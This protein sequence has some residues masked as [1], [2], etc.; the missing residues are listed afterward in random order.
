MLPIQIFGTELTDS[1]K[2]ALAIH[3]MVETLSGHDIFVIFGDRKSGLYLE[4]EDN[5]SLVEVSKGIDINCTVFIG[6]EPIFTNYPISSC[7]YI[8]VSLHRILKQTYEAPS[9]DFLTFVEKNIMEL[10]ATQHTT[11]TKILTSA[12]K[13][14]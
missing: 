5:K 7:M 9:R 4:F 8:L 3:I 11:K 14:Y 1:L 13:Y 10:I 6:N 2:R 12:L